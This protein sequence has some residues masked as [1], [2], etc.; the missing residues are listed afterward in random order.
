MKTYKDGNQWCAVGD[1]FVDL[2][3]SE[4]GFGNTK[5]Q[6]IVDLFKKLGRPSHAL[7]AQ[8]RYQE[9]LLLTL[10]NAIGDRLGSNQAGEDAFEA[11]IA[12]VD[13]EMAGIYWEDESQI[14]TLIYRAG[15]TP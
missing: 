10:K 15:G 4:A 7:A 3:K 5:L 6:A 9:F 1:D 2:V 13:D 14:E 8:I 11:L 12:Q